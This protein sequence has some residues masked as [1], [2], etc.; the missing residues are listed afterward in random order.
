MW[1]PPAL[2]AKKD[3]AASWDQYAIPYNLESVY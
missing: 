1:T 3:K 2:K